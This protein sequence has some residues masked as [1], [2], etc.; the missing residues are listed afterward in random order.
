M[1]I[2]TMEFNLPEE[3]MEHLHCICGSRYRMI[4]NEV[5]QTMRDQLKYHNCTDASILRDKIWEI[6][7]SYRF[8]P[9]DDEC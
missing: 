1:P 5:A 3:E 7:S 9:F 6:F 8:D 2:A 4:L